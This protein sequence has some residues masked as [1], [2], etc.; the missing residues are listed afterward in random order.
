VVEVVVDAT[1]EMVAVVVVHATR[2]VVVVVGFDVGWLSSSSSS[3][4]RGGGRRDVGGRCCR[5]R[6]R[7]VGVGV[8]VVRWRSTTSLTWQ[9]S[10]RR[11]RQR[12]ELVALAVGARGLDQ[13]LSTVEGFLLWPCHPPFSCGAQMSATRIAFETKTQDEQFGFE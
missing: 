8:D 1:P 13:S 11:C 9:G 5:S 7:G 2:D 12:G 6:R 4:R 3:S 10:G